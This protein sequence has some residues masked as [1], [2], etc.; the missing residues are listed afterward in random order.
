MAPWLLP[1]A[2]AIPLLFGP[3]VWWYVREL[4]LEELRPPKLPVLHAAPW[5]IE[6]CALAVLI[7]Y[8]DRAEWHIMVNDI[9]SRPAPWWMTGRNA[10]KIVLGTAYAVPSIRLAFGPESRADHVTRP[11][12]LWARVV[13]ALLFASLLS[14]VLVAL[15]PYAAAVTPDG[16]FPRYYIPAAVMMATMYGLSWLVLVAPDALTF[17]LKRHRTQ[18]LS[19]IEESEFQLIVER[20]EKRMESGIYRDPELTVTRLAKLVGVHPNRLSLVINHVFGRNFSHLVNDHRLEYFLE[21]AQ[22]GDLERFSITRLAIEAGFPSKS[23]FYRIFR[24][25]FG[26]SPHAYLA[27]KHEVS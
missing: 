23:T 14:F 17:G 8:L 24:E 3:L 27:D 2:G 13:V 6:T 18:S 15:R 12:R 25:H 9:F 26:T 19:E 10:L 21:R 4:V 7:I 16:V 20:V 11:R 22:L 1:V 5:I